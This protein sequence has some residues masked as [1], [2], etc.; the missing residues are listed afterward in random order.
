MTSVLSAIGLPVCLSRAPRPT[1]PPAS[2]PASKGHSSVKRLRKL[3]VK[4]SSRFTP[5]SS[6]SS[7]SCCLGSPLCPPWPVSASSAPLP[8]AL[9]CCRSGSVLSGDGLVAEDTE[10]TEPQCRPGCWAWCCCLFRNL[11]DSEPCSSCCH[12]PSIGVA[13]THQVTQRWVWTPC[14]DGFVRARQA[15]SQLS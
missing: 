5:S 7:Q 1:G 2:R 12:L 3:S 6:A 10:D 11:T 4:G 13:G 9:V 15:V 14:R 8:P